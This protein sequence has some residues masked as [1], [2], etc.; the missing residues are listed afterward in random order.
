MNP[1]N[2]K[3]DSHILLKASVLGMLRSAVVQTMI[4]PLKVIEMHQQSYMNQERSYQVAYR[5]YKAGGVRVFFDG[6]SAEFIKIPLRSMCWPMIVG[7]PSILNRYKIG[8]LKKQLITG[9]SIATLDTFVTAPLQ[10][11]RFLSVLKTGEKLS[12][13]S[14]YKGGWS[15]WSLLSVQWSTFLM[16]QQYLK[17]RIHKGSHAKLTK[18]Q[19]LEVACPTAVT[20]SVFAA[21]FKTACTLIQGQGRNLDLSYLLSRKGFR[22]WPMSVLSLLIHNIASVA[23]IDLLEDKKS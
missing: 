4:S 1:I 16:A 14:L 19:L 2:E 3:S 21:V 17:D 11:V 8:I 18:L 9:V 5:L 13:R 22:G 6:L 10:K 20:V 23:L 15:Y 7:I 12:L